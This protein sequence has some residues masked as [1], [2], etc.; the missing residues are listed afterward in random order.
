MRS[1]DEL[2]DQFLST[3]SSFTLANLE[4]NQVEEELFNL[5][6]RAIASFKFPKMPLTY[7][8]DDEEKQYFFDED[9]TQKEINVLVRYM[10][11]YWVEFQLKQEDRLRPYYQDANVRTHSMGNLLAQ[12][13]RMRERQAEAA[14]K[15]EYDYGRVGEDGKPTLGKING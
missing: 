3:I 6:K 9:L 15:A 8:Y 2:Y 4:D 10:E 7:T 12:L 13:N 5:A 1:F 14:R 11:L